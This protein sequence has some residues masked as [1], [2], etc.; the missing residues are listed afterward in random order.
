MRWSRSS[1]EELQAKT[2]APLAFAPDCKVL[3]APPIA[4]GKEYLVMPGLDPGIHALFREEVD[5]RVKPGHDEEGDMNFIEAN[6]VSLRYAVEGSGKPLVLIHEM[7][8]RW[9]AGSLRRA[10][11]SRPSGASS[12]TT[13]AARASRRKSAARSRSTR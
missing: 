9:K 6:G 11:R 2:G 12:A 4:I 1:R 10:A 5:C 13:R 7:G 8:G 3:T